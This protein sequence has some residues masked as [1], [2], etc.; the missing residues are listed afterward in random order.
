MSGP[1]LR[2]DAD[3]L[4]TLTLNRPDKMNALSVA[5]FKQ[6]D[7]HLAEIAASEAVRCVVLRGAGPCFSTGN[8]LRG[9]ADGGAAARPDLQSHVIQRL[10]R[11]PQPVVVAVHGHCYTG[12]LELA[13]AGDLIVAARSARFGDTHAKF[14]LVPIWGMTQRLP[15]RV[16]TYKAREIM[17]TCRSYTGEEAAAMGLANA[18][19]DDDVFD[20][21]VTELADAI[22]AQSPHS[23]R[24]IK[25][26][27]LETDGFPLEA[28]LAHETYNS[29]GQGA[30]MMARVEAFMNR[31][32]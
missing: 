4:C 15:R 11:L 5:L 2:D 28:G 29:P 25:R 13:L 14:A 21:T 10:A 22:L 6:L 30:D 8:D 32:R 19:V 1:I 26:L 23:Q 17:F 27:L 31:R 18:C 12:A 16:G 9:I 7:R 3:G 24:A 20:T